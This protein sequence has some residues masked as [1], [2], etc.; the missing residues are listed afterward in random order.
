MA[1]MRLARESS[2]W[3]ITFDLDY[4]EPAFRQRLPPPP[5]VLLLRVPSYL[6]E[7]PAAWIDALYRGNKL[8]DGHFCIDDGRT[9]RRWPVPTWSPHRSH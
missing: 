1:V 8:E 5:L 2:R 4:G 7:D 9:V 3:L 6:P